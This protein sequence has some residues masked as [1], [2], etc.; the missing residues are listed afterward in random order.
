M[1]W[2]LQPMEQLLSKQDTQLLNMIYEPTIV[3]VPLEDARRSLC[4]M[5]DGE[6]R[7]YGSIRKKHVHDLGEG[8]YLASRDCGLSWKLYL[9]ETVNVLGASVRSPYSGKYITLRS[10][11]EGTEQ[12]TYVYSSMKGPADASPTAR[13][14]TDEVLHDIFQPIAL[15]SRERWLCTM[16]RIQDGN[17]TPI[18]MTSDDDGDS[19]TIVSLPSTPRHEAVWPHLGLR[20]QNNG[21]EPVVTELPDGKLMLLART[22]LDYFY[23]YYS[24]DG[25]DHWTN[26][27]PSNFHS[28]LTTPFLLKMSDARNLL[29]WCNT[30][31]LPEFH[32]ESQWPPLHPDLI[33]GRWEDVFTNRDA[34]HAAITA[35]GTHWSGFRELYLSGLRND[36]DFRTKGGAISSN[37]K[38]VHQFQAIELPN[39]KILVALGQ[40]EIS[41]RMIIFDVNWLYDSSRSERFQAGLAHLSTQVFVKSVSGSSPSKGFTG[42]CAWNRTDGAL[43]VP[44]PDATHGEVLQL[45]RIRD[46]RLVSEVQGAVW[47]FPAA[48]HGELTLEV[49]IAGSGVRL[50]LAD[51]WIHPIDEHVTEYAAF[52]FTLTSEV[53]P[54]DEWCAIRIRFSEERIGWAQVFMEDRPLFKVQQRCEAPF[55]LSYL[56]VQSLAVTEDPLGT[57]IRSIHYDSAPAQ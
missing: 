1:T 48:H 49:R 42:H 28:T 41:R 53:L 17:Y 10:M 6:I 43:L 21:A 44:D 23:V 15:S 57:Y 39:G 38:S 24:D 4:V 27:E 12:G 31:P 52:S 11:N 16:H 20:W 50:S 54:P 7:S 29:F 30:R 34:C 37:D 45:G 40:H 14:I 56:H 35:D 46:P 32:H 47:N 19:W 26:G 2:Y 36:A 22:S 8:A 51:H 5:P 33:S 3:G 25:G 13:K 55:G 9:N 18:V